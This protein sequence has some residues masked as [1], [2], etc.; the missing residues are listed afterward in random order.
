MWV[1][2]NRYRFASRS[3]DVTKHTFACLVH[4]RPDVIADLIANLRALEPEATL[5]LYDGSAT[6]QLLSERLMVDPNVV[7]HPTPQPM[8]WGR[9]HDFA[10]D[11]MRFALQD[12]DFEA[13]TIVDSD[14]LL[15]RPGY[16]ERVATF[17][18]DH[19]TVG[20]LGNAPEVQQRNSAIHPVRIAWREPALWRPFLDRL[21][22][23]S[24]TFPHWTFWPSTVFTRHAA[25]D[26]VRLFEDRELQAILRRTRMFATEEIVLPTLVA[27]LGYDVATHPAAYDFVRYRVGYDVAD[28]ERALA[29][30]DVYWMHPVP[31]RI[32][33]PVR[34]RIRAIAMAQ[35]RSRRAIKAATTRPGLDLSTIGGGLD[36]ASLL[37]LVEVLRDGAAATSKRHRRRI[38]T[39]DPASPI[40][41][42][43]GDILTAFGA[44][45][46][47]DS[48][49][50]A[51]AKPVDIALL[52][53]GRGLIDLAVSANEAVARIRRGGWLCVSAGAIPVPK[54]AAVVRAVAAGARAEVRH[55]GTTVALKLPAGVPPGRAAGA[56]ANLRSS[57]ERSVGIDGWFDAD[58]A[59]LLA[60]T[61]A[62]ALTA[63]ARAAI[64]E[65]GSFC[66]RATT[67]LGDVARRT[68]EATVFAIDRFDGR[69]GETARLYS[70]GP[71]LDRFRA[72]INGAG[73][74]T[75]VREVV[76]NPSEVDW[77]SPIGLLLVD[78]LHD[79][80]SVAADFK[81]Y[82]PWLDPSS[83]VAFHDYGSYPGVN[84]FVDEVL[85]A[86][87]Y[88][89]T[90]RLGSLIVLR[91]RGAEAAAIARP[92]PSTAVEPMDAGARP[93]RALRRLPADTA[94]A[95]PR[96][97]QQ[98]LVSCL[99]PT[100]NRRAYVPAAIARFLA[101]DYPNRELIVVDDGSDSIE[102]LMPSDERIRYIRPPGR[103]TI[104]A[105]RNLAAELASGEL[106]A[107]WDDDDWVAS[108]RLSYEVDALLRSDAD[109]VGLN[110]L[111]YFE[112]ASGRAWRYAYPRNDA[113]WV[114]DP[115][116]CLRR[117]T[118]EGDRFPDTNYSLDMTYLT[119]GRRKRVTALENE[120]FYVGM[121]H[122]GNTSRKDTRGGR[123][124]PTQ[125]DEIL[126]LMAADELGSTPGSSPRGFPN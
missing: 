15:L 93:A 7:I 103:L 73:L 87:A 79:Y 11:S 80:A 43:A 98:P 21:P 119:R 41:T 75:T 37:L 90:A 18:E 78:G 36:P 64:V 32:D 65:I 13:L 123:W 46:Q 26:L 33:D 72:A 100:Y 70:C 99:M 24:A 124:R 45:T 111:L 122:S 22:G 62:A 121:I 25:A 81:H 76:G 47:I 54:V 106:L 55:A 17:L 50:A 84:R 114:H 67:V 48:L 95:A 102:D 31:R 94:A 63:T 61:A 19:P 97:G 115:T 117:A 10:I 39:H 83:F 38:A 6:G 88:G 107:N 71:T 112:P 30:P 40:A 110:T 57:V 77:S 86:G 29:T 44:P 120:R 126:A 1:R 113:P 23:G 5:L 28:V 96:S 59:V 16:G 35:P 104:G 51:S 27:A 125:A 60:A 116:L 68:G 74:R 92:A 49:E 56:L 34:A 69:V 66:G 12:L 101:Q 3:V 4:E 91:P 82:E 20:M 52:D 118:W 89:E 2:L 108:W 85:R 105:K 42:A 53:D 8:R 58:E 109:V 9:L 14:Q